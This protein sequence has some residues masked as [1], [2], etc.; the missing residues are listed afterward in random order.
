MNHQRNK[1]A[2]SQILSEIILLAIAIISVSVIYTQVLAVPE[3]QDIPNVTI[4]GKIEDGH[5]VFDLQRGESLERDTK[6]YINIAGEYNKSIYSL[7]QSFLQQYINNLRWNIGERIILPPGNIPSHKGPQVEGMIVDAK[8]NAIVFW[9]ILQ[10]G[11]V[12]PYK[13]GIWHFNESSWNGIPN[14][15]L[16]SSGNKNHG[17]AEGGANTVAA[18]ISKN[19]G[20]FDG[21][22]DSV[23][24]ET[25]WTL[26]MT[27]TITVEAWMRPLFSNYI[28]G[29]I[30]INETFGF[31]P[32]IAHITGDYYVVVSEDQQKGGIIQTIKIPTD[33][34][35]VQ[36]IDQ[37]VFGQATSNE[38]LRPIITRMNETRYLVAY[39]DITGLTGGQMR[40][41]L[42]TY[43]I[44]STGSIDFQFQENFTNPDKS[45]TGSANRPSLHRIS[46]NHC[47]IACWNE[48]E[49]GILRI[50]HISST[51]IITLTEEKIRYDTPGGLESRDPCLFQ[52]GNTYYALAYHNASTDRGNMKIFHITNT[53][54][55]SGQTDVKEFEIGKAYEPSLINISN[56]FDSEQVFAV[57]YRNGNDDGCIKTFNVSS[58]GKIQWKGN[59]VIFDTQDSCFDPCIVHDINDLYVVAYSTANDGSS[60]SSTGY[61]I[62]LQLKKDGSIT[63]LSDSKRAFQT[64]RC[65]TPIILPIA[66]HCF[67]IAYTGRIAHEG[68]V[69]TIFYGG[70]SQGIYKG[71]SFMVSS[72]Q[73]TVSGNIM[74]IFQGRINNLT[75]FYN[76]SSDA[77]W[78][79]LAITYDGTTVRFYVDSSLVNESSK[80][81]HQPITMTSTDLYFGRFYYG[82]IDEIAIYE[83]ALSIEQIQNHFMY[84]GI[85]L[86]TDL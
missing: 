29:L 14:E 2:V 62:T 36:I 51:G 38:L 44:S 28:F 7:N 13:G 78:H 59:S 23:K 75:L 68:I 12:T 49:G 84:P 27:E 72:T 85:Y 8:T 15:V 6:I 11:I 69:T 22:N 50:V 82:Y 43:D 32:Y 35:K 48:S 60:Q 64:G 20:Y 4:I 40:V 25:S 67:T 77:D 18:V 56:A 31:T 73:R 80:L 37:E 30:E 3:P 41:Q 57:A 86:E 71:D 33:R 54:I 1:K 66:E 42:R 61:V 79:H 63:C 21:Y 34:N 17:I 81:N 26:N 65:F 24:V 9:G 70:E 45:Q 19:A 47:A 74:N 53:G 46:D 5:P 58:E 76:T 55:I 39:N 16:D 83:K 10:E 52:V